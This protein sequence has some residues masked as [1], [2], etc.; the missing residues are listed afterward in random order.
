MTVKL[1][2]TI[3]FMK[4]LRGMSVFARIVEAGS[5]SQAADELGVSKSVIS[6]QLKALEDEVGVALLKRTTRK[7]SLTATGEIFYQYCQKLNT[8]ADEALA[9][10]RNTQTLPQG[11]IKITA[12]NALMDTVV[13][14]AVASVIK[15]Y[16]KIKPE[17]LSADKHVDI[18]NE[19]IDLAIRVG[20]SKDSTMKQ[21]RIGEFRDVFCAHKSLLVSG[22]D[23]ETPYIANYWQDKKV[24][25]QFKSINGNNLIEYEK[26]ADVF[27][28]S[29]HTC[30]AL[31]KGKIGV[32]LLPQF[33]FDE[34]PELEEVYP[35][36][37]LEMNPIYAIYPYSDHLPL[38]VR[39]CLEEIKRMIADKHYVKNKRKARD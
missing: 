20:S 26:D 17:F 35:D 16:P 36:H 3:E 12:S 30:L 8:I 33:L 7:Q 14:P 15:L 34:V 23:S 2:R 31:L 25:H 29:Y 27:S 28:N 38:N 9:T 5:I 1:N 13:V 37:R 32:G 6:Q 10:V 39:V 24:Y 22:I 11:A 21:Q 19:R 4:H 18:A